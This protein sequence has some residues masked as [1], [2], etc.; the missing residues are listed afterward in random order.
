MI[1]K[2]YLETEQ[3]YLEDFDSHIVL[4]LNIWK[5]AMIK[6]WEE[7]FQNCGISYYHYIPLETLPKLST[8]QT[9]LQGMN[10]VIVKIYKTHSNTVIRGS[11]MY[12]EDI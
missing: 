1:T 8:S 6:R 2:T 5:E 4:M 11:I 10:H 7:Y 9:F 3:K 12:L